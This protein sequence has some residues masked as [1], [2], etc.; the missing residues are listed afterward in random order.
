MADRPRT[1]QE[2]YNRIRA[3]SKDEFILEDMIRLGFWPAAGR[4]NDPADEIRRQA[5]VLKELRTFQT[6]LFRLQNEKAI[7]EAAHKNRLKASR[8]K[9]QATRVRN[10]QKRTDKATTWKIRKSKEILFLGGKVSG[11]LSTHTQAPEKL[12]AL[13]LPTLATPFDLA[14][15]MSLSVGKLRW[16]AYHRPVSTTCH[17][18]R[19][20]I[21]KKTGG[22]RL[23]SAPMPSLKKAQHWI[24]ANILE[25]I[26]LHDAAHGFVAGR[27]IVSNARPHVGA[28]IVVNMD[29][30]DFFPSVHWRRV[31]GLFRALGYSEAV[32]TLLGLICS[33][34]PSQRVVLDGKRFYV[35]TGE[36]HLPQGA[37]TSPAI[38]NLL[39][40][41]LDL[42]LTDI[43]TGMG[44]VYTRY[45]DDLTFSSPFKDA[46]VGKLL[47]EI[48]YV[49]PREGFTV[50]PA[51]TRVQRRGRQQEVTG[52]VVND[53]L[54]VP[55]ETLKR[56]RAL[57]FQIEKDGPAGK[58]WG[59][60]G[61][62]FASMEGFAGYVAMV[63]AEKGQ[64]LLARV[65]ALATR[66]RPAPAPKAAPV[67]APV[68]PMTTPVA[69]PVSAPVPPADV[70]AT[71]TPV[72][73]SA[74]KP[75]WKLF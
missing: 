72:T 31:R 37:P 30:K 51:K 26:P 12:R 53:K 28:G 14:T 74:K 34:A 46:A 35:T 43:A 6:E 45:A 32:S 71:E 66:Y 64:P 61:D 10:A 4:P 15:A 42:R 38:T 73:E 7:R 20:R 54:G 65:A 33:E 25:K 3:T 8:E 69:T 58:K 40:R 59:Q 55:R 36:R 56:F 29:L 70:V 19:F 60:G 68:A 11:G 67:V 41:N 16:L 75:W 39:C 48:R 21:P 27:S 24:L 47:R 44:F 22:E 50:H 62:L 18:L 1:R 52:L 2:L 49:L 23:I 57:L 9:Q 17:Y 5:D 13:G 63:D